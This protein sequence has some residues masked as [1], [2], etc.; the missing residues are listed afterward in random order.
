MRSVL[1]Q[2]GTIVNADATAK[3]DLLIDGATIKEIRAG[4][5]ASAAEKVV[6]ASG[7]YLLPGG[8]DAPGGRTPTTSSPGLRIS[9]R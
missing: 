9:L 6:D 5:P 1:I 8:V 4:I 3:A 2:N 7:L